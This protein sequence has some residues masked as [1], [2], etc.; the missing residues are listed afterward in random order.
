MAHPNWANAAPA[1][2]VVQPPRAIVARGGTAPV[3]VAE[4]IVGFLDMRNGR[5][6]LYA[7]ANSNVEVSGWTACSVAG[8]AI[9]NV[10]LFVDGVQQTAVKEFFSRADVAATF[11]RPDFEMSGWKVSVP[12]AGWKSGEHT[13]AAQG[14]CSRGEKGL[15]PAFRLNIIE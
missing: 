3:P 8:S 13:L 5:P 15:L 4:P 7:K 11:G 1:S 6:V 9:R 10:I 2:R 12:L 14:V